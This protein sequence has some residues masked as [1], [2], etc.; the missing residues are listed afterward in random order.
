MTVTVRAGSWA[1]RFLPECM[2]V[3]LPEGTDVSGL[4]AVLPVPPAEVGLAVMDDRIV[5]RGHVL[6]DGDTLELLPVIIGG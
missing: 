4:L 3:A 1:R 6:R 2:D 5:P